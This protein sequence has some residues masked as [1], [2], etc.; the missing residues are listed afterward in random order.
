MISSNSDSIRRFLFSNEN[1]RLWT[2]G[3]ISALSSNFCRNFDDTGFDFI[4][5][6]PVSRF[7]RNTET[8]EWWNIFQFAASKTY[9]FLKRKSFPTGRNVEIKVW[10]SY[11]WRMEIKHIALS[12]VLARRSQIST[13][14]L[15]EFLKWWKLLEAR[16]VP[17]RFSPRLFNYKFKVQVTIIG[18]TFRLFR[19]ILALATLNVRISHMPLEAMQLLR[20]IVRNS[21]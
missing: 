14:I 11:G 6:L 19:A 8:K 10:V 20:A 3:L 1:E 7:I 4:S 12:F 5:M 17:P 21:G 13:K 9:F 15:S 16:Q 18:L 2:K